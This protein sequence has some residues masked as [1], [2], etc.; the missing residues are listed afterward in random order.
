ME[1]VLNIE[2]K[3]V[4]EVRSDEKS[5]KKVIR[6]DTSTY[7][8]WFN[9]TCR[10]WTKDPEFNR[11]FLQRIQSWMNDLLRDQGYLFLND[12]YEKLG[13]KKTAAGQVVGWIYDEKNPIGD[14]YIDFGL[15]DEYNS[16]FI[17]G[18]TTDALL[19]FNVDG[20]IV[21]RI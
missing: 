7:S 5:N 16:D 9:S 6:F 17:N 10:G 19:D 8:K 1:H 13:I 18:L 11:I 15:M 21:D 4:K 3:E 12:V 2:I 20:I 14:N